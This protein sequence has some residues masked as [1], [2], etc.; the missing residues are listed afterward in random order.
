MGS[1]TGKKEDGCHKVLD[2]KVSLTG[3][4]SI[5]TRNVPSDR[6]IQPRRMMAGGTRRE[7]PCTL[8]LFRHKPPCCMGCLKPLGLHY[9]A[10]E[11]ETV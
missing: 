5:S 9:T 10:R 6:P 4:A 3:T 2:P 1:W 8:S 7:D 11:A